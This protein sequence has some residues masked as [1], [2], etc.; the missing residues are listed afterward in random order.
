M[1]TKRIIIIIAIITASLVT[2][3][4]TYCAFANTYKPPTMET[5]KN[6]DL[7]RYVGTWYEIARYP[8]SFEK[9]LQGVTATYTLLPNGKISV[10][11]QGYKNGLDGKL[12][13]AKGKA[14]VPDPSNT[15]HLQVAFFLCFYADYYILELDTVNYSYALIGSSSPNYL[16]ILSRTPVMDNFTYVFLTEKAKNLGYDLSRLEKVAQ[17]PE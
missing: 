16:W 2:I 11:N 1:N 17:K 10:L 15:G 14:R 3:G 8:H 7:N 6:V 9:N 4:F 13:K 5:V 12:K